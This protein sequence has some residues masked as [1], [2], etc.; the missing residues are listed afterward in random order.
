M[1]GVKN[2]RLEGGKG[3]LGCRGEGIEG[4]QP[5]P[6]PTRQGKGGDIRPAGKLLAVASTAVAWNPLPAGAKE[7]LVGS[8]W[9]PHTPSSLPMHRVGDKVVSE[10]GGGSRTR[11]PHCPAG[12][13][14]GWIDGWCVC[15]PLPSRL[16]RDKVVCARVSAC[17]CLV[18][19]WRGEGRAE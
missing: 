15:M 8:V 18:G 19:V 11:T 13:P 9:P 5:A 10:E 17:L 2:W 6:T 3:A 1:C 12:Y 4:F 14:D 7:C 16:V